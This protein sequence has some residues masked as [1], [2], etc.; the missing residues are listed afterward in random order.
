MFAMV[1][2]NSLL[3]ASVHLK[4]DASVSGLHLQ[5]ASVTNTAC[6]CTKYIVPVYTYT[7]CQC[8]KTLKA[9]VQKHIMSL[10]K[11]HHASVQNHCVPVHKNT[12]CQCIKKHHASV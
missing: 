10:Y 2:C 9:S 12:S 8:T 3:H 6:Q 1:S 11:K 5:Y 7:S 4:G